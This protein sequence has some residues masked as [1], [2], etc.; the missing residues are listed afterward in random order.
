MGARVRRRVLT[1][2][3]PVSNRLAS[4]PSL[5]GHF[6]REDHA[7]RQ[8]KHSKRFQDLPPAKP[9]FSV[10]PEP[11]SAL[12]LRRLASDRLFAGLEKVAD[13]AES[14][15]H[16]LLA[17]EQEIHARDDV[18]DG[19]RPHRRFAEHA[20]GRLPAADPFPE[21]ERKPG[22]LGI[23][24]LLAELVQQRGHFVKPVPAL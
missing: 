7:V 13:C 12:D 16:R 19:R 2:S 11:E 4:N 8:L 20:L 21:F 3:L 24:V 23:Q 1:T 6:P 22:E 15:M 5:F 18:R 17:I 14:Q 10:I 9:R